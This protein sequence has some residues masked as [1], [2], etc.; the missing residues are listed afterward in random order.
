M[1]INEAEILQKRSQLSPVKQALLMKRFSRE[2]DSN[3]QVNLIPRRLQNSHIPLS[4]AQERLWLLDQLSSTSIYNMFTSVLFRGNLNV[5]VL[6]RCIQEIIKRHEVLRTAFSTFDGQPIQVIASTTAL[7]LPIID[8]QHLPVDEQQQEIKSLITCEQTQTFDLA[9]GA[10]LQVKLLRLAEAEHL[11]LVT[12]HHIIADAWSRG[13]FLQE[14]ATLYTAFSQGKSYPLTELPIQ[15]ADYAVWQRQQLQGELLETQLNYWKQQLQGELPVLNLP[16]D[17][18]RLKTQTYNGASVSFN[19]S[20]T[21][22]NSLQ[23]LSRQEGVT[24][25]ITLLAAFKVLLHRYTGQNDILVGSPFANRNR[26]EVKKLIGF[27]VN[28]LVLRSDLSGNP[29]FRELLGR[30]SSVVLG[31][32]AHQDLSF[33][34]LLESL[35]SHRHSNGEPPFQVMFSLQNFPEVAQELPGVTLSFPQV[36]NQ[37]AFFDLVLSLQQKEH[38][39]TAVLEYNTDLFNRD[40]V[41]RMST[42]R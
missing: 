27:L 37:T 3:L 39:L 20:E 23:V 19:L 16:T 24:L 11:M 34:K 36:E 40:T 15:Y 32:I 41:I 6:E 29:S 28:T 33:E 9:K 7:T 22:T 8:L 12:I 14:L 13:V 17:R 18:P 5:E 4:Y 38:G 25:F 1:D 21:L 42:L 31:A 10:L 30:V 26:P 2:A 35:Q